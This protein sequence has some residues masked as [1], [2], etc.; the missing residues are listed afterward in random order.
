[1][2]DK[3]G[4]EKGSER[5]EG[6]LDER[7]EGRGTEMKTSYFSGPGG[8]VCNEIPGKGTEELSSLALLPFPAFSS[9]LPFFIA[10]LC[11]VIA[12]SNN[13]NWKCCLALANREAFSSKETE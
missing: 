1:M 2:G 4:S 7:G 13:M 6:E 10:P 9:F 8:E 12:G 3:R 11:K 5:G